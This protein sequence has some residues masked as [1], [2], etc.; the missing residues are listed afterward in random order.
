MEARLN[1]NLSDIYRRMNAFLD[2]NNYYFFEGNDKKE[3]LQLGIKNY[4]LAKINETNRR[5][6]IE[7]DLPLYK[8]LEIITQLDSN[9]RNES[10]GHLINFLLI[11]M[12][13]DQRYPIKWIKT[14][15]ERYTAQPKI[16]FA[17][18]VI[19]NIETFE[20]AN[21]LSVFNSLNDYYLNSFD[22]K[23]TR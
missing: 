22:N 19:L 14:D 7:D 4:L 18:D 9:S 11:M 15:N 2:R 1:L 13:N 21:L 12:S 17:N 5:L 6:I 10:L 23:R 3:M 16:V 8:I 20:Q